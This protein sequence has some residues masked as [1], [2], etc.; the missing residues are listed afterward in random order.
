[1]EN[2]VIE[3]TEEQHTKDVANPS[4][5]F[6]TK[7]VIFEKHIIVTKEIIVEKQVGHETVTTVQSPEKIIYEEIQKDGATTVETSSTTNYDNRIEANAHQN[8]INREGLVLSKNNIH[9]R[10]FTTERVESP[11]TMVSRQVETDS[12]IHGNTK[13]I[14]TTE[15]IITKKEIQHLLVPEGEQTKNNFQ[16]E[17]KTSVQHFYFY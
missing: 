16:T 2:H 13:E 15:T 3:Q 17:S 7:E 14:R 4:N 10:S 11:V 1:M 5:M 8:T 9:N 6:I 12:S